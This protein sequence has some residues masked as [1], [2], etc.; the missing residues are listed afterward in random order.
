MDREGG[1]VGKGIGIGARENRHRRACPYV[2]KIEAN[3]TL[4]ST[5]RTY[6]VSTEVES[7]KVQLVN[8]SCSG[9]GL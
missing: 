6:S 7:G 5:V 3:L 1:K 9:T 4:H 2:R 8:A